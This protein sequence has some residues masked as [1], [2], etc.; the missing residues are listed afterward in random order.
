MRVALL[1]FGVSLSLT[2][3][4]AAWAQ[5][6][7]ELR[8]D[9]PADLGVTLGG[10]AAWIA[11]ESLK[12]DLAPSSCRWCA[13]DGI[14]DSVRDGLRWSNTGAADTAS[15]VTAFVVSP[16]LSIG[17]DALAA[18]HDHQASNIGV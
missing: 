8:Y 12:G 1:P 6:T 17:A 5:S 7:R 13:V 9:L 10:G 11:S 14:D 16:V 3:T 18:A 4:S 2:L 15:Y